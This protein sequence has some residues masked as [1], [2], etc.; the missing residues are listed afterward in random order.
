MP[1]TVQATGRV[2][3]APSRVSTDHGILAVFVLDPYTAPAPVGAALGC[4]VRCRDERL[5]SEVLRHG[6]VGAWVAV[7]GELMLSAV[8]G[9]VEDEL[10]VVRVGIEADDVCFGSVTGHRA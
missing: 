9:P 1:I 4:E 2:T 6:E 3:G 5:V 10:C 7:T 8:S